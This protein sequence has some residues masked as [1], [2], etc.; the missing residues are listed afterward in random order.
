MDHN[1]FFSFISGEL[2]A[3]VF[4]IIFSFRINII[5]VMSTSIFTTLNNRIHEFQLVT[6]IAIWEIC[7]DLLMHPEHVFDSLNSHTFSTQD[8]AAWNKLALQFTSLVEDESR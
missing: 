5:L 3:D 7:F 1:Q 6:W 8:S 2:I 4:S